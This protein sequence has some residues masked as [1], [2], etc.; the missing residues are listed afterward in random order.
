MGIINT[1]SI[2]VVSG[3]PEVEF[4]FYRGS[5]SNVPVADI[6]KVFATVLGATGYHVIGDM[7]DSFSVMLSTGKEH[8][9]VLTFVQSSF[10][11]IP[12]GTPLQQ[13]G[14]YNRY[15]VVVMD[16]QTLRQLN[17]PFYVPEELR[18]SHSKG[19]WGTKDSAAWT[20]PKEDVYEAIGYFVK[21]VATW[22]QLVKPKF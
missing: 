17:I 22:L 9:L 12:E 14:Q 7:D 15:H 13:R 20:S 16:F 3:H 11:D 2:E 4:N 1:E 21:P 19:M 5:S 10:G 6:G 8:T 18:Y